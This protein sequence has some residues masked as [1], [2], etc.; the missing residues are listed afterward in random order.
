MVDLELEPMEWLPNGLL[1]HST[2][3]L[4]TDASDVVGIIPRQVGFGER[5]DAVFE[6]IIAQKTQAK[7]LSY[8]FKN[9]EWLLIKEVDLENEPSAE[10]PVGQVSFDA[11]DRGK[12]REL[13]DALDEYR[14][15][16]LEEFP[17]LDPDDLPSRDDHV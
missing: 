8:D 1:D 14:G 16:A 17:N 9:D 4:L 11:V 3:R 2:L 15:F 6:F 5:G 12:M 13:T 7:G 10:D